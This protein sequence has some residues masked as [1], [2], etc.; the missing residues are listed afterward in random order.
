MDKRVEHLKDLPKT[1]FELC[2]S[3]YWRNIK[4]LFWIV[5]D[6]VFF[7]RYKDKIDKNMHLILILCLLGALISSA[8]INRR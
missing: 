5:T 6:F 8:L 1:E 3:R 2:L 7:Y 4:K